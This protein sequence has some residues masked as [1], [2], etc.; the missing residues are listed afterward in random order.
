MPS[1]CVRLI[2]TSLKDEADLTNL[3]MRNWQSNIV[4]PFLTL[5]E[6]GREIRNRAVERSC[7]DY[8]N[9]YM[10]AEADARKHAK[11]SFIE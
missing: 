5:V 1:A 10:K 9:K 6:I 2:L 7:R 4:T 11:V 3:Q 8:E